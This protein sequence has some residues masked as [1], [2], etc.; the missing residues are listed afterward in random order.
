MGRTLVS[1]HVPGAEPGLCNHSGLSA[2]PGAVCRP[3]SCH[4]TSH[5]GLHKLSTEAGP[6]KCRRPLGP[7]RRSRGALSVPHRSQSLGFCVERGGRPDPAGCPAEAEASVSSL[8]QHQPHSAAQPRGAFWTRLRC[9]LWRSSPPARRL[10]SDASLRLSTSV[11]AP[12]CLR[13][14]SVSLVCVPTGVHVS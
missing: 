14:V 5:R 7:Q 9:R 12:W 11:A 4:V 1:Q 13:L 6:G 3:G 10:F 2:E 8:C